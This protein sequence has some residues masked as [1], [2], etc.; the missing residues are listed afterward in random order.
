MNTLKLLPILLYA[1]PL[2][3]WTILLVSSLVRRKHQWMRSASAGNRRRSWRVIWILQA[4][5]ALCFIVSAA[6]S[7]A[8]YIS[9]ISKREDV[10]VT[11]SYV[12][13]SFSS[14]LW[15]KLQQSSL[16]NLHDTL[17]LFHSRAATLS[18]WSVST[19]TSALP[20]MACGRFDG[21]YD[22]GGITAIFGGRAP[23]CCHRNVWR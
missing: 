18:G 12:V 6:L 7:I 11:E 16:D 15:V 20:C 4:T 21:V 17:V 22:S 3:L 14:P 1:Y 9:A 10:R 13:G 8:P 2:S 5:L 19:F 23:G